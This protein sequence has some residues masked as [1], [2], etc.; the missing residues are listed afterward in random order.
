MPRTKFFSLCVLIASLVTPSAHAMVYDN[1]YIPLIDR[2]RLVPDGDPSSFYCDVMMATGYAAVDD[3]ERETTIPRLFG[4]F[5]QHRLA[6]AMVKAGYPNLLPSAWRTAKIPWLVDGKIQAQGVVLSYFQQILDWL[7]CGFSMVA[8][9][10]NTVHR[11]KLLVNRTADDEATNL[12][13]GPGDERMLDDIRRQMFAVLGLQENHAAQVGFGDIDAFVRVGYACEYAYKLRYMD[14]GLRAG[15]L[16]P[17][18]WRQ[19]INKPSS[20]PFG[21]DGY[22][23]FY[24]GVDGLFEIKED[25]KIGVNARVSHRFARTSLSRIPLDEEPIIFGAEVGQMRVKP[26][27]TFVF[28]PF[29]SMENLRNGLGVALQ[30]TLTQHARDRYSDQRSPERIEQAPADLKGVS[31][32]SEWGSDYITLN[33]F[34]D[35]GKVKAEREKYPLFWVRWDVPTLFYMSKQVAKTHRISLG[36]GFAF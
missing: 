18:G 27:T 9:R 7:S 22:W 25:I 1:R 15:A 26:G 20:I 23:G 36:V 33:I 21:G 3:N 4:R 5:D 13:L 14:F 34:Y 24:V 12:F 16:F 8:M 31:K 30:Y 28:S 6:Q 17:T 35:F 19:E 10:V 11:F 29:V 2:P 32:R